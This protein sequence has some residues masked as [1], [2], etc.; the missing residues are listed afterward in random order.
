MFDLEPKSGEVSRQLPEEL[1]RKL[2]DLLDNAVKA[3]R[4]HRPGTSS[5]IGMFLTDPESIEFI[6]N[7]FGDEGYK[8]VAETF[9]GLPLHA[10]TSDE[11]IV[12][13]VGIRPYKHGVPID[14][15]SEDG[16]PYAISTMPFE[17]AQ[18]ILDQQ[19]VI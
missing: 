11:G 2:L 3:I 19:S 18:Q 5:G 9:P 12:V 7:Y 17:V 10:D 16:L 6:V 15:P 13:I 1:H 8:T 14:G 4:L